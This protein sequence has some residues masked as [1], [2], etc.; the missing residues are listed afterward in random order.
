[1]YTQ[2]AHLDTIDCFYS[3]IEFAR[4]TFTF[5]F[6]ILEIRELNCLKFDATKYICTCK[7]EFARQIFRFGFKKF[8][9]RELKCLRFDATEYICASVLFYRP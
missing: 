5:G 2:L 9:I 7:I 6:K 4:Q 3:K 8:E 1:M